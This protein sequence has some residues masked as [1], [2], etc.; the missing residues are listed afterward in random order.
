[1][2]LH[3]LAIIDSGVKHKKK[4]GNYLNITLKTWFNKNTEEVTK[5]IPAGDH[6]IVKKIFEKGF[7]IKKSKYSTFSCLVEYKDKEVGFFL[8]EREHEEYAKCGGM[9][10]N[11]KIEAEA[12]SFVNSENEEKK[13]V[14]LKF[15]LVE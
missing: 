12:Y 14:N 5:G 6:I 11:V 15:S 4:E 2:V 8:S 9:E 3:D 1:M 13:G 7:E 10:D